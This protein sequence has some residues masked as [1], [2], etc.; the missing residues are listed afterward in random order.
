MQRANDV[1]RISLAL[2]LLSFGGCAGGD[3]SDVAAHRAPI[4][5]G[6]PTT[7]SP[8]TV[9]VW[10]GG[11]SCSGTLISPHVVLTARH[12]LVDTTLDQLYVMFGSDANDANATWI[13]ATDFD[14]SQV[15][16]IGAITLAEAGPA[17]PVPIF[18][19]DLAQHVGEDV[20]IVGFGVT[21]EN[22]SDAGL[23]R[24]GTTKLDHVDGDVLI[25]GYTGSNTCYGDSGGP[26][27]MTIDG[28]EVVVG[29][30]SYGTTVCGQ[31]ED[32]AVRT[33]TYKDWID[34]Y[35]NAHDPA[36]CT[37]DGRCATGCQ[38]TDP[39]CASGDGGGGGGGNGN[40]GGGGSGDG[41][42]N[43]N[44]D[45]NDN[46]DGPVIGGDDGRPIGEP[47]GIGCAVGG[48]H[49]GGAPIAAGFVLLLVASATRR[50][51]RSGPARSCRPAGTTRRPG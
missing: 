9:F 39:D 32:G 7:G 17:T 48:R 46:G 24:E 49:G 34:A 21:S 37:A 36:S 40:G 35:V 10:L 2:S 33:D 45:G 44:G 8:A 23:K 4:V 13:A 3:A 18:E 28:K 51:R 25:T 26:N 15:G 43:G 29:A 50:C 20:H 22:G 31:P 11:G 27:Y 19:G 42:G 5:N 47:P 1:F 41:G 16:D 30:T 38:G 6:N 12:C 14:Y